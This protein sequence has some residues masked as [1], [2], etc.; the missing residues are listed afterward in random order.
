MGL[1]T[2]IP[3]AIFRFAATLWAHLAPETIIVAYLRPENSPGSRLAV[4]LFLGS[5][6]I[7][8]LHDWTTDRSKSADKLATITNI[9]TKG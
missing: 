1:G 9:G 2:R 6:R 5:S 8:S 4:T 7:C 3:W